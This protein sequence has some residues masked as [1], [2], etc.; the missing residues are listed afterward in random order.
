LAS[1]ARSGDC[2]GEVG[3]AV[4]GVV[5]VC[6][7]SA[8]RGTGVVVVVDSMLDMGVGNMGLDAGMVDIGKEVGLGG[9]KLV[10]CSVGWCAG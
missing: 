8:G 9:N 4:L 10:G 3:G 2:L 7:I 6:D 5:V 1:E